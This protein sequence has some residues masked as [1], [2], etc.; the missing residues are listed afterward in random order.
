M[1]RGKGWK[2]KGRGGREMGK[3]WSQFEGREKEEL[4]EKGWERERRVSG[5]RRRR[6][7]EVATS[8]CTVNVNY[9]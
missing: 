8:R 2:E 1:W 7:G 5:S 3:E 4:M 6:Q 9:Q